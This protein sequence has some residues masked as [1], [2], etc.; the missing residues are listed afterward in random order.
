MTLRYEQVADILRQLDAAKGHD[1]EIETGDWRL[2][3]TAWPP[4]S[5]TVA[6]AAP[7]VSEGASETRPS[8]PTPPASAAD[9][10]HT[11][12]CSPT[13][14][15]FCRGDRQPGDNVGEGEVIAVVELYGGTRTEIVTSKAGV[16][17]ELLPADGSFVQYGEMIGILQQV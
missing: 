4:P 15:R 6:S 3:V 9:A 11:T 10:S 14:G 16:L 2:A 12:L 1:V 17:I 8:H 5:P 13:V 7:P